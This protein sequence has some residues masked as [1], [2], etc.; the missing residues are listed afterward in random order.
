MRD[1]DGRAV[2]GGAGAEAGAPVLVVEDDADTRALVA[3]VLREEGY[4]VLEAAD[5]AQALAWA[6]EIAPRLIILDL[7]LPVLDGWGF[8]RAYRALPGPHAPLLVL[9]GAADPVAWTAEVGGIT[10]LAKPF[11]VE[12]LRLLVRH[13]A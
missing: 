11:Q 9:T 1:W 10:C 12:R 6:R 4:A 7:R 5:G 8:A 2:G 3:D 13:L